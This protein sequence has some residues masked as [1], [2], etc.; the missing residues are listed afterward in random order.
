M[1]LRINMRGGGKGMGGPPKG[2]FVEVRVLEDVG[3]IVT[4]SGNV[5]ELEK[6]TTHFMRRSEAEPFLK[7]GLLELV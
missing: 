5:L 3:Q 6:N 7:K 2:L 1:N 4:D